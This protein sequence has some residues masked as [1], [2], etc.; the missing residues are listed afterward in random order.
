MSL[1]SPPYSTK[2][3]QERDSRI[4]F[5]SPFSLLGTGK[6]WNGKQLHVLGHSVPFSYFSSFFPSNSLP[7]LIQSQLVL[8]LIYYIY[9]LTLISTSLAQTPSTGNSGFQYPTYRT[10]QAS[11]VQN[12]ISSNEAPHHFSISKWNHRSF[13]FKDKTQILSLVCSFLLPQHYSL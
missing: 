1:L 7:F 13:I 10:A 3:T 5:K 11:R 6:W 9:I 8:R 2:L 4:N 12:A